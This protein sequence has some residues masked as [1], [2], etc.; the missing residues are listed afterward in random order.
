MSRTNRQGWCEL[1]RFMFKVLDRYPQTQ[2]RLTSDALYVDG[3]MFVWDSVSGQVEE[4]VTVTIPVQGEVIT[5]AA[6][7]NR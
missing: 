1:H 5:S 7:H 6:G 3:R 2:C 4:L